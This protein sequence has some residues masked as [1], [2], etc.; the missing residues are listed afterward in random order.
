[1]YNGITDDPMAAERDAYRNREET[2]TDIVYSP[3]DGGYYLHRYYLDKGT[4]QVSR[5]VYRTSE[6]ARKALYK[7]TVQWQS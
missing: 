2:I 4:D 3:D 7:G 1:M 5:R 6:A